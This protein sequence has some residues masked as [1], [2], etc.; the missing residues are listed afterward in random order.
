MEKVSVTLSRNEFG[1]IL[2]GI[3]V[4]IEQWVATEQYLAT[5][6]VSD[7]G[8]RDATDPDEAASLA[9]FYRD[10]ASRIRAQLSAVAE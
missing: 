4:L 9:D 6:L 2:D 10:I 1:Q 5:G 7:I 8:I 3:E